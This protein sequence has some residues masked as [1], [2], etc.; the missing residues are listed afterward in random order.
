MPQGLRRFLALF[1]GEA[2]L[3]V[4]GKP[5]VDASDVFAILAIQSSA[6]ESAARYDSWQNVR[7]SRG[8][9][10]HSHIM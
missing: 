5:E 6:K 1:S 3:R 9:R 4:L 8:A 7:N 10:R 2:L